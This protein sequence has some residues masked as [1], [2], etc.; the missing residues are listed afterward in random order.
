VT[1]NQN[2]VRFAVAPTALPLLHALDVRSR[3]AFSRGMLAARACCAM[4]Y[5]GIYSSRTFHPGSD[6]LVVAARD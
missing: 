2:L 6:S 3:Y 1:P 4:P 5:V